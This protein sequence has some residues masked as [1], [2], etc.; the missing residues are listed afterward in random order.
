MKQ[1][2]LLKTKQKFRR[3]NEREFLVKGLV[4]CSECGSVM[5]PCFTNKKTSRYYYYKCYSVV[6]EGKNA[7]STKSVNADKLEDFLWQSLN[8]ISL[9]QSYLE[10]WALK[11]AHRWGDP[12]GFELLERKAKLIQT[13]LT[14]SLLPFNKT[15]NLLTP[16]EKKEAL[17]ST[18]E[19]IV[20]SKE[21]MELT[22]ATKDTGISSNYPNPHNLA[23]RIPAST[24]NPSQTVDNT[25]FV[26]EKWR[27]QRD[28]NPRHHRERVVSWT[29]LD[30]GV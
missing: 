17:Q 13:N 27:P 4:T 11:M 23:A 5:T 3:F 19:Q 9:D 28:L 6:R 29:W 25:K 10:G 22:L 30:D 20:F 21:S 8:R 15:A 26:N 16:L 14:D 1:K 12:V 7:C 24:P 18:I 2:A